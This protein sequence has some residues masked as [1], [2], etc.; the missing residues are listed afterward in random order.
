MSFTVK[1][2]D[3]GVTVAYK[4]ATWW[5]LNRQRNSRMTRDS[6]SQLPLLFTPKGINPPRL[7]QHQGVMS[8]KKNKNTFHQRG[9]RGHSGWCQS[10][11]VILGQWSKSVLYRPHASRVTF[12]PK[13]SATRRG[14]SSSLSELCPS[15]P[16]WPDPNVKTTP[17]WENDNNNNNKSHCGDV[18]YKKNQLFVMKPLTTTSQ[19]TQPMLA[20][21]TQLG[22]C[23]DLRW[24]FLTS[25]L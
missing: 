17:S 22:H 25:L 16:D 12:A 7:C 6:M 15:W 23:Y 13:S 8:G 19:Q 21:D 2:V 11:E 4:S 5:Q 9:T 20:S 3:T 24:Y 18:S 10:Q 14:W 1:A